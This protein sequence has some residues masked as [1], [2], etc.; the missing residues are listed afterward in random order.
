MNCTCVNKTIELHEENWEKLDGLVKD[1]ICYYKAR[2]LKWPA[3]YWEAM[4]WFDTERGEATELYLV[5][6]EDG[7][8]R[9]NPSE[10]PKFSTEKFGEEI[11][12]MIMLAVVAGIVEGVD[13]ISLLRNKMKSKLGIQDEHS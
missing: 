13:P 11:G 1:I 12:D 5:K 10:Q 8:V 6:D 3:N 9:N 7:W 2:G 4:G